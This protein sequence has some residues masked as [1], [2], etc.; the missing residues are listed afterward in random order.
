MLKDQKPDGQPRRQR[1]ADHD[2]DGRR[3]RRL[4]PREREVAADRLAFFRITERRPLDPGENRVFRPFGAHDRA[5]FKGRPLIQRGSQAT[6]KN[7]AGLNLPGYGETGQNH[8]GHDGAVDQ[9]KEQG[10]HRRRASI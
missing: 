4:E 8:Q 2:I 10:R 7:P 1:E 3:G 6:A 9:Y 5:G